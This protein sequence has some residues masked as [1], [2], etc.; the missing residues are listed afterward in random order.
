MEHPDTLENELLIKENTQLKLDN[1][2]LNRQLN[3]ANDNIRKYRSA[4]IAKTN[5]SSVIAAEK[6][7]QE[8]QLRIIMDNSPDII[9]LFDRAMNF[10]LS[11]QSFL[12]SASISGFGFLKHKSFRQVF[13]LF[14]DD[15]WIG[16]MEDIF[17]Q[18]LETNKT[19][20]FDGNFYIGKARERRNYTISI[21]PFAY[22]GKQIEGFLVIFHDITERIEMENKIKKALNEATA[23]NKAKSKFLSNMSHEIRTPMNAITGMTAIAESSDDIRQIKSAINKIKNASNHLL[24]VINDILDMSKIES[25]KFELSYTNVDIEKLFQLVV[26][27][28]QFR[29]TE[30]QQKFN[31]NI[32]KNIP[33]TLRCDG[34]RLAQVITNLLSNAVKFTPEKGEISLTAELLKDENDVCEIKIE[35]SDT[36][37]G[38]SKEHQARLFN[39]FEQAESDTNRK[40]GGTG[41]GLPISK[42]IVEMMGDKIRVASQLN[43]GSTFT[44]ILRAEKVKESEI[45]DLTNKVQAN[46]SVQIDCYENFTILLAEDIEINRE[47]VLA[48]LEPTQIT[49]D[50]AENGVEAVRMFEECPQRYD[51]IFMDVQMPEMDGYEATRRIRESSAPNAQNIPIVA[52][53]ANVFREDVEKCL[54]AGMNDHVGKP[55]NFDEVLS[56]LR[57][58]LYKN[59][60]P[61]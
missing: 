26:D 47:I 31:V 27:M 18:A 30:K 35:V 5:L 45:I 49:I 60:L 32:D 19:Q 4:T 39:P 42:L 14:T 17:K 8:K 24:G 61:L 37:I 9:I 28:I 34:Q 57:K 56:K 11:T 10:L 46:E 54:E 51:M 3:L 22:D 21:I 15:T 44:F 50:C 16:Q 29:V 53:T 58:Y 12:D 52:M 38:I 2:K 55:L 1:K 43:K 7:K 33:G 25:G 40:F 13:S 6:S 23:A 20:V 59:S 48:L 41:L 36:G